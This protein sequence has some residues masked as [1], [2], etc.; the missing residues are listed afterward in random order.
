MKTILLHKNQACPTQTSNLDQNTICH[1]K[2]LQIE[3]ILK[4][5]DKRDNDLFFR[6]VE[7]VRTKNQISSKMLTNELIKIRI[8]RRNILFTIEVIY[9]YNISHKLKY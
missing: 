2:I 5:L 6:I 4:S 8:M 9:R 3:T 1:Q 7:A